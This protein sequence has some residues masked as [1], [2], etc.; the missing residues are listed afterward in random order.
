MDKNVSAEGML[1]TFFLLHIEHASQ[2]MIL[3]ADDIIVQFQQY[4]AIDSYY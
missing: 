2:G 1:K 4:S 3:Q